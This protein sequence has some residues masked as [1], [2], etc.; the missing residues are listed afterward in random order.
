M[1]GYGASNSNINV[2]V[3][4]DASKYP[5]T[6]DRYMD[7]PLLE[8]L[9]DDLRNNFKPNP[10]YHWTKEIY[11]D[12]QCSERDGT[13]DVLFVG[14]EHVYRHIKKM[15]KRFV[16]YQDKNNPYRTKMV[17]I[18]VVEDNNRVLIGQRKTRLLV[19]K[20]SGEKFDRENLD[21]P[22]VRGLK[23]LDFGEFGGYG[24]Y[25]VDLVNVDPVTSHDVSFLE[26]F[27]DGF[28]KRIPFGTLRVTP[29]DI[30][31]DNAKDLRKNGADLDLI[32]RY[33]KKVKAVNK[34]ISKDL[35]KTRW[36]LCAALTE[37]TKRKEQRKADEENVIYTVFTI[38]TSQIHHYHYYYYRD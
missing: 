13:G 17:A 30:V 7:L 16:E 5:E 24:E 35:K 25:Q 32:K 33:L 8:D 27:S 19:L 20:E 28:P 38:I 4:F 1:R 37:E 34:E 2:P 26:F 15:K 36:E 11:H 6:G 18:N 12:I 29:R 21:H 23:M 22:L 3:Y 10:A 9:F 14:Y 31:R